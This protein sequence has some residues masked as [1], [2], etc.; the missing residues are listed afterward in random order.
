[1]IRTKKKCWNLIAIGMLLW[2]Y[3]VGFW[4]QMSPMLK[5]L[6]QVEGSRENVQIVMT[7]FLTESEIYTQER[8][9]YKSAPV[10]KTKKNTGG[11]LPAKQLVNAA[12]AQFK[13]GNMP[14][15]AVELNGRTKEQLLAEVKA[16]NYVVVWVTVGLN[17]VNYQ[18]KIFSGSKTS[19]PSNLQGV[20]LKGADKKLVYYID[21]ITGDQ[22][23]VQDLFFKR[24]QEAG[25]YAVVVQPAKPANGK[26]T[27]KNSADMVLKGILKEMAKTADILESTSKGYVPIKREDISKKKV[28]NLMISVPALCAET[29]YEWMW[30][31]A[32]DELILFNKERTFTFKVDSTKVVIDE[33]TLQTQ[34]K[35]I[36]RG[37]DGYV[38]LKEVKQWF[39]L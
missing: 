16:G 4:G 5:F 37:H 20:L 27:T 24:Y 26:K 32:G 23:A 12:N 8:K 11:F 36:K 1:M 25:A 30:S 22:S 39:G 33:K 14:H 15:A 7:D 3:S 28:E 9:L 29:G 38:P 35:S 17:N 10:V 31:L 2:I 34:R 6:Q 21:P 13:A 19:V 18:Q